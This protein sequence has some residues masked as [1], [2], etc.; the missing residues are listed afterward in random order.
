MYICWIEGTD[1]HTHR[2]PPG[3]TV[4]GRR[5]DCNIVIGNSQVSRRHAKI[6]AAADKYTITDLQSTNGTFVNG[7]YITEQI[8]KD[9]DRIELGKDR[10][11]L[12]F[13]AEPTRF[14]DE[15]IIGFERAL[16][17]LKITGRD[18]ST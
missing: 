9:G 3:E 15:D 2:L 16:L 4:V 5:H 17:D 13:S 10:I 18:E 12:L 11:P 14:P 7:A 1:R 8:L 6:T